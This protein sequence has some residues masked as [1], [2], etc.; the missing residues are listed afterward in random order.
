M[1]AQTELTALETSY[2][3]WISAGMPQSYTI[4]GRTFTRADMEKMTARLDW[5]R[6]LVDRETNGSTAVS[7]FRKP[8]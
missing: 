8:E 1:T 3:A 6:K 5:L 4:N 7:A 2:L